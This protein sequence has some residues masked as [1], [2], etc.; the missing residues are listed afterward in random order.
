M[1]DQRDTDMVQ[2]AI[3]E[4]RAE[5]S[6][7]AALIV[8]RAWNQTAAEHPDAHKAVTELLARYGTTVDQR[9]LTRVLTKITPGDIAG[10]D[11]LTT[12]YNRGIRNNRLEN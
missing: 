8:R 11:Y 7:Q 4:R 2:K 1:T 9:R 5:C 12:A 10:P 3:R 6:L